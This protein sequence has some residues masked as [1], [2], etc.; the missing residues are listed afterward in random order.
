LVRAV[1]AFETDISPDLSPLSA[2]ALKNVLAGESV[3]VLLEQ[4]QQLLALAGMAT[5]LRRTRRGLAYPAHPSLWIAG[6]QVPLADKVQGFLP[7]NQP[8]I[9][10]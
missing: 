2:H 3:R 10:R 6:T 8:V 5:A 7:G 9:S 4:F 1:S